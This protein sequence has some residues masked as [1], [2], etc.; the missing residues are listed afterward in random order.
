MLKVFERSNR[1]P[2]NEKRGI[3]VALMLVKTPDRL[4]VGIPGMENTLVGMM[5]WRSN[6]VAEVEIRD[7]LDEVVI[8]PPPECSTG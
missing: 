3:D 2:G 4:G 7:G 5:D 6:F 1:L 8:I